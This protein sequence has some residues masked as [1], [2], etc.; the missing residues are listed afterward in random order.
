MDPVVYPDA[1]TADALDAPRSTPLHLDVDKAMRAF[2]PIKRQLETDAEGELVTFIRIAIS[3][4]AP[5]RHPRIEL[6][7]HNPA[8][9]VGVPNLDQTSMRAAPP[10]LRARATKLR[11]FCTLQH[12]AILW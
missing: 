9:L 11:P 8:N 10:Q 2:V 7:A 1:E 12:A 4:A 3:G 6:I 5:T